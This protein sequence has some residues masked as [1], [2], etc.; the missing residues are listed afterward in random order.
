MFQKIFLNLRRR[1]RVEAYRLTAGNNGR[2]DT[3]EAISQKEKKTNDGGSSRDLRK[4]LALSALNLLYAPDDEYPRLTLVWP[5]I[6]VSV[7]LPNLVDG[8]E[9]AHRRDDPTSG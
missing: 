1:N 5:Q 7:N 3:V 2:Q 4:A 6:E 9:S 8:D